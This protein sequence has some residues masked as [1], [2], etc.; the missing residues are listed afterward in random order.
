MKRL[1]L[2]AFIFFLLFSLISY[3]IDQERKFVVI[4]LSGEKPVYLHYKEMVK[5]KKIARKKPLVHQDTLSLKSQITIK[6]GGKLA[7][8]DIASQN[9]FTIKKSGFSTLAKFLDDDRCIKQSYSKVFIVG[10][11]TMLFSK[12][13]WDYFDWIAATTRDSSP[14][15][16]PI[17]EE[18]I[19]AELFKI[20]FP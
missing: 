17:S 3:A 8:L 13:K 6:P 9:E 18:K 15:H 5:G 7:I 4:G 11:I 2:R 14:Y 19:I 10:I 12:E 1:N 20:D 16:N